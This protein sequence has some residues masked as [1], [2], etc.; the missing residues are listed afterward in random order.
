MENNAFQKSLT[1]LL[2]KTNVCTK[3]QWANYL[4]VS[5]SAISQW[6]NGKTI[7]KAENLQF[8][9]LRLENSKEDAIQNIL[10]DFYI[11]ADKPINSVLPLAMAERLKGFRTISDYIISSQVDIL[12]IEMSRLPGA[13]KKEFLYFCTVLCRQI[14]TEIEN[15]NSVIYNNSLKKN[16]NISEVDTKFLSFLEDRY[17]TIPNPND[18]RKGQLIS[19]VNGSADL[20]KADYSS[21]NEA[22]NSINVMLPSNSFVELHRNKIKEEDNIGEKV[23]RSMNDKT[24]KEFPNRHRNLN[25]KST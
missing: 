7:P 18:F 24:Q 15:N 21:S 17:N 19:L 25:S 11:M 12:R 22:I 9:I 14:K 2:E 6:V 23:E 16:L 20:V 8:I 10:N 4:F 3:E 5:E 1:A 13:V